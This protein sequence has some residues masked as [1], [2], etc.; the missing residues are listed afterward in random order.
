LRAHIGDYGRVP[1]ADGILD[2]YESF[3]RLLA[4]GKLS[5]ES[6]N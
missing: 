4:S 6:L 5:A 2:T 1:L 3:K